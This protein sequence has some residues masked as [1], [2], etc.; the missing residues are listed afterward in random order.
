L[1]AE[2]SGAGNIYYRGGATVDS[3]TSGA[4]NVK[5]EN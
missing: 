5:N 1:K 3:K 2:A 4:G